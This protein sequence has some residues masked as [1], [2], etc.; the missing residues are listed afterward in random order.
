MIHKFYDTCS[1]LLMDLD[2]I[3]EENTEIVLCSITLSELENIKS[4]NNKDIDIKLNARKLLRWLDEH[5]DA[6]ELVPYETDFD[7]YLKSRGLIINNDTRILACAYDYIKVRNPRYNVKFVT[8][9]LCLK[10]LARIFF[11]PENILSVKEEDF[12]YD[13]YKEIYMNETEMAEFYSNPTVN[14]GLYI[15]QYLILRSQET[16]EIVDR[17]VWT[18]ENY[19]H[20]TF[21]NFNSD[22]FGDV[23]PFKNDIYQ[24]FACDSFINNKITMIKGPAGSGKTFLSLGYLLHLL[25]RGK[26]DKI[27]VFCN[28]VATKN[29]AKLGFYPGTRDE[30]LLD[31]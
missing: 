16:G 5:I 21:A 19:R 12:D 9:D 17:L 13:G 20:I 22:Y 23:K 27:I 3:F 4:S 10:H 11:K 18:G 2:S 28:T 14:I 6:Y 1:L 30:K 29:S 7:D 31:S 25:D 8:N 24:Q 26:I 15:N